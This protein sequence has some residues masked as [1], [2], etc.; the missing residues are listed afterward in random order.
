[1]VWSLTCLTRVCRDGIL[2]VPEQITSSWRPPDAV[3]CVISHSLISS[4]RLPKW[5]GITVEAV[6]FHIPPH[7]LSDSH[8]LA[9]LLC[10]I[11]SFFHLE[12]TE[13]N[14]AAGLPMCHHALNWHLLSMRNAA[15]PLSKK[16]V[17]FFFFYRL[18]HHFIVAL[19]VK[20]AAICVESF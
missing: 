11:V 15:I 17:F 20:E 18:A 14:E 1:M 10:F 6:V 8:L 3:C 9:H 13:E 4:S 7:S 2:L 12:V 16:L 5:R 19:Y